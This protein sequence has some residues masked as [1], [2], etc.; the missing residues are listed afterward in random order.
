MF[1]SSTKARSTCSVVRQRSE[2]FTPSDDAAH[3]DL[4]NGRAL[5]GMEVLGGQNDVELAVHVENIA[6][7]DGRGDDLDHKSSL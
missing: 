2:T 3:V 4:G 1:T 6:L 5:A 7:A